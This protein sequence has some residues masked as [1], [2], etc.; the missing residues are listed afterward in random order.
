MKYWYYPEK[1]AFTVHKIDIQRVSRPKGYKHVFKYGRAKHGFVYVVRGMMRDSFSDTRTSIDVGAGEL[2][3]IPKGTVYT[4]EYL[5]DDTEIEIVQFNVAIGELPEYLSQPIKLTFPNV[6]ECISAFFQFTENHSSDHP[7]YYYSVMYHFLWQL[8]ENY[9]HMPKK[10]KKL[11]PALSELS[12][13]WEKNES[14]A[15]YAGLCN[16]SEA[17][18]RRLFHEYTGKTPV[19]YRNELR[20]VNARAR[21]R[22]GEYT[23][24]ETAESCGFYNLSYFIRCY[25]KRFGCTPKK[26]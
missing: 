8:E 22:S 14:V 1:P 17:N 23:V 7:F 5:E 16:M 15:Y 10:Y 6:R 25:K 24:S 9:S 26:Q 2:L 4:G 11:Q 20:L 13:R 12:E 3:F 21:L 19:E 18:F